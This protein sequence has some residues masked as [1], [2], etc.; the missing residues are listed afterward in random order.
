MPVMARDPGELATQL[1]HQLMTLSGEV[2]GRMHDGLDRLGLNERTANLIWLLNPDA[3]PQ[4]LRRLAAQLRCDPSNLTL[5]SA[6]LEERGLAERRPHP[7]DRRVRTL[8]LT[9]AGREV[10]EQLIGMVARHSPL[11]GLSAEEQQHLQ[12]LL[13]KAINTP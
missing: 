3:E 8:V 7:E 1:L 6:K 5:L 13:A 4:P 12:T 10:R 9:E 11:S 2:A